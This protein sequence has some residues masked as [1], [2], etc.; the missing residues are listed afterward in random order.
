M[1]LL[2]APVSP[3]VF[4]P[5]KENGE[6]GDSNRYKMVQNRNLLMNK[7]ITWSKSV[8][9]KSVLFSLVLTTQV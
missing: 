1:L 5:K 9:T 2:V 7:I 3:P 8:W 6:F 4:F